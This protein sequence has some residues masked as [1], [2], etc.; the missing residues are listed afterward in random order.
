[1]FIFMVYIVDVLIT[2]LYFSYGKITPKVYYIR[3]IAI[4]I[5]MFL[6]QYYTVAT[7]VC[8]IAVLLLYCQ[9]DS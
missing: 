6:F 7:C 5:G 8:K 3:N 1:M 9:N 2:L 4:S